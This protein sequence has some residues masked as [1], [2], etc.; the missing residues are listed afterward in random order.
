[1]VSVTT[2]A[3]PV[4]NAGED[5][6]P[7]LEAPILNSDVVYLAFNKGDLDPTSPD[8]VITLSPGSKLYWPLFNGQ[9]WAKSGSGTQGLNISYPKSFQGVPIFQADTSAF[10]TAMLPI[11]MI[12]YSGQTY[13]G[14]LN[15]SI[16]AST[17]IFSAHT[18]AFVGIAVYNVPMSFEIYVLAEA[19]GGG[20][21]TI[22]RTYGTTVALASEVFAIAASTP[23]RMVIPID[24]G[25]S[26]NMK[27]DATK[28][29]LKFFVRQIPVVYGT[30]TA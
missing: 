26:I 11:D 4:I 21:L 13:V 10:L 8:A 22:Y 27:Y 14:G 23:T 30:V 12:A 19:G 5:V 7:L 6:H 15:V 29:F 3:K 24:V 2:T 16:T 25:E 9:L 17:Y 1:M 20:N 18:S 28:T